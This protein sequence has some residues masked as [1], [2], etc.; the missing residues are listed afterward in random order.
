MSYFKKYHFLYKRSVRKRDVFLFFYGNKKEKLSEIL[1]F[2]I[3]ELTVGR[4]EETL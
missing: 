4:T 1:F 3:I 2:Y